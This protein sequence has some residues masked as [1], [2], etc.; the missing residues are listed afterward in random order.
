MAKQ[1]NPRGQ[2]SLGGHL[3]ELRKRF[4]WVA[5]FLIAGSVGGWYLFDPV[6]LALQ[7]PIIAAARDSHINATVNF[8]TIGGAFDLRLQISVFIGVIVSSPFW[9]YQFWAFIVPALKRK[10]RLYTIGFLGA[11]IPLFLGGCFMAWSALPTFVKALLSL[12]PQGSANLINANEYIL[13]AIRILLVFG[14]AFVLPV[15]LVLLNFMGVITAKGIIKGWRV[16]TVVA[17]F[18]AA[19]ATPVA[20][21]TSMFVLMIPLMGLYFVSAGIAWLRDRWKRKNMDP[22]LVI[23][24]VEEI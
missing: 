3:K 16:A 21:P 14:I 1:K 24:E 2:M 13:F 18:I 9:L 23:G 4:F 19:L 5:L 20:D 22:D 15:V 6:F 12:T 11:A 7:A 17:A 10:E 8:G